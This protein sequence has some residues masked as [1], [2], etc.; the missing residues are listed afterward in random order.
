MFSKYV[1]LKN[2]KCDKDI[3]STNLKFKNLLN[4]ILKIQRPI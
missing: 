2:T 3:I 1:N 4:T